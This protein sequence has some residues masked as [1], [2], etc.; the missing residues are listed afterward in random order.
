MFINNKSEKKIGGDKCFGLFFI[1]YR[2][3]FNLFKSLMDCFICINFEYK[4]F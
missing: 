3:E 1:G 2:C 4:M